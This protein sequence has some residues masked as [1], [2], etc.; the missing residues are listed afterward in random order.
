MIQGVV[1][2]RSEVILPLRVRGS[3]GAVLVFDAVIDTGFT[4]SLTLPSAAVAALGLVRQSGDSAVLA[5]GSIRH[6][7]VYASDVEWDANWRPILASA[8]GDEILVGMRL[9]ARHELRLVVVPGGP[10][11]INPL[12]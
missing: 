5:D 12:P 1:N 10:V 7:G 2:A 3:G 4:G 11:E 6:F 8:V 9:L